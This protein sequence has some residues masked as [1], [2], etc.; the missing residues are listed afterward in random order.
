M[1]TLKKKLGADHPS[2]LTSI[3]T[4]AYTWKG[5]GRDVEAVKLMSECVQL[6]CLVLGASH[7][8][9]MASL[10]TLARWGAEQVEVSSLSFN[11]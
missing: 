5:Q 8:D 2:T 3:N 1:E 10:E 6:R 7:P 4:L 9:Y 11:S